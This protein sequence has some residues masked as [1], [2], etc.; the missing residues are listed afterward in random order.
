MSL[1]SFTTC[2]LNKK[3]VGDWEF[4]ELK[5]SEKVPEVL[6]DKHDA[7]LQD[8]VMKSYMKFFEDKSY[9]IKLN[10][11]ITKGNWESD[12]KTKTLI[13]KEIESD[14]SDVLTINELTS[15]KMVLSFTEADGD[16]I[17]ISLIRVLTE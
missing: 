2:S 6:K 8:V 13:T 9:E 11:A 17:T 5:S 15:D 3:V 7:M 4:E 16:T 14:N 1:I 10:D 12:K